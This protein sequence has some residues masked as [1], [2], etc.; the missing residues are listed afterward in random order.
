MVSFLF[1]IISPPFKK[2]ELP[3]EFNVVTV[4]EPTPLVLGIGSNDE[5]SREYHPQHQASPPPSFRCSRRGP[6]ISYHVCGR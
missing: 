3:V 2:R 6:H 1:L 5:K 4:S